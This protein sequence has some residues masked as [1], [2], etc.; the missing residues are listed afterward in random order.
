MPIKSTDLAPEV[1]FPEDPGRV[2][3]WGSILDSLIVAEVKTRGG[4]AVGGTVTVTNSI[5]MSLLRELLEQA[6][7]N[8]LSFKR[9][10][11]E[12]ETSGWK[13]EFVNSAPPNQAPSIVFTRTR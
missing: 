9:L 6:A 11:E 2:A 4:I 5:E 10:K 1:L 3:L 7:L 13:V 12:F 8:T